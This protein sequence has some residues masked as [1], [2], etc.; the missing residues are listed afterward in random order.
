MSSDFQQPPA[1]RDPHLWQI[2]HRRAS[3][4]SHLVTYLLVNAML[5]M[6][7]YFSGSRSFNSDFPWPVWS[8]AGWGIGLVFH[9]L[10]A[11]VNT[12]NT[13]E[14]EYQKLKNQKP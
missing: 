4:K 12:G 8:T 14:S 6:I 13:I 2:A 10:G 9:Y 3:F 5:W 1:D 11:Y 7:W